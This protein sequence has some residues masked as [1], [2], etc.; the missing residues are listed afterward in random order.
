[1]II[2][3]LNSC[4]TSLINFWIFPSEII[5]GDYLGQGIVERQTEKE[6]TGPCKVGKAACILEKI[7]NSH[8]R[9]CGNF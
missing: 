9:W 5:E 3:L 7:I 6:V 2:K 1:M 4:S 8:L